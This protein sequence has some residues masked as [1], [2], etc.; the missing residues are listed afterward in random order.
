MIIGGGLSYPYFIMLPCDTLIY[1]GLTHFNFSN[2]L[3]GGLVVPIP[4]LNCK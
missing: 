3:Q 4:S 2:Y 1:F